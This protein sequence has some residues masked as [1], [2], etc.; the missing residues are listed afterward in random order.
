MP[1]NYRGEMMSLS[2][3]PTDA[4]IAHG[5]DR[6]PVPESIV[7]AVVAALKAGKNIEGTGSHAEIQEAHNAFKRYKRERP[8]LAFSVAAPRRLDDKTSCLLVEVAAK[9][10]D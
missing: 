4:K 5:R 7:T 6:K 9:V 1:E 8:D 10:D 2:F 3:K